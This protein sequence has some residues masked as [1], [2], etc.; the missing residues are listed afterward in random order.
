MK[1]YIFEKPRVRVMTVE[2]KMVLGRHNWKAFI[3]NYFSDM[4][5]VAPI[6]VLRS[7]FDFID[8]KDANPLQGAVSN[9]HRDHEPIWATYKPL[10]LHRN[11]VTDFMIGDYPGT[12]Y[13]DRPPNGFPTDDKKLFLSVP[14]PKQLAVMVIWLNCVL[15]NDK[16]LFHR[17]GVGSKVKQDVQD[18][19]YV[20]GN[21]HPPSWAG[22]ISKKI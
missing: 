8:L 20:F 16:F 11:Y 14:Y 17:T 21:L 12:G 6:L 2:K 7:N 19:L 18:C 10:G 15:P 22:M 3:P 1:E 5:K 13:H 4:L 9:W